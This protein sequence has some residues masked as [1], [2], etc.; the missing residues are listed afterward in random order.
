VPTTVPSRTPA[1]PTAAPTATPPGSPG[2]SDSAD[3]RRLV[4]EV[5]FR[6]S[7][8]R[9]GGRVELRPHGDQ[10]D[11]F[12]SLD[13]CGF[14]FT[15]EVARTARR[16]VDIT[17]AHAKAASYSNEV[18]A[19]PDE[20]TAALAVDQMRQSVRSCD[21]S[22]FQ[23]ARTGGRYRYETLAFVEHAGGFPVDD[24]MSLTERVTAEDGTEIYYLAVFLHAGTLLDAHYFGSPQQPT[25]KEI[26]TLTAQA[27]VTADR[28][29]ARP[30]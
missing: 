20:A 16:Q 24:A 4:A 22:V 8:L 6:Q 15:T 10:V 2:A 7:D 13:N 14:D 17:L 19:Y 21:G 3:S 25:R 23:T 18:V 12:A 26:A 27:M 28:L 5:G 11:G 1:A 9:G 29:A 30:A